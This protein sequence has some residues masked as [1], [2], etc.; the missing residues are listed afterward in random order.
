MPTYEF[1]CPSGHSFER[2]YRNMADAARELECPEC[3]KL[4]AR[5]MSGGAGLVFKGSGF[6]LTD[7]GKNAHRGEAHESSASRDAKAEA[8][9]SSSGEAKKDSSGGEKPA[10]ESKPVESK[11][12][13]KSADPKSKSSDAKPAEPKAK[14]K[15]RSLRDVVRDSLTP[16]A[17]DLSRLGSAHA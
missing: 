15:S 16:R 9:A 14:E 13:E 10:A 1:R 3:G 17:L 6:Y 4:A 12:T 8:G 11:S 5:Q 2:F 7:Y